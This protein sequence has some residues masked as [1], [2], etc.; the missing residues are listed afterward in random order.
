M[1]LWDYILLEWSFRSNWNIPRNR[2]LQ[3]LIVALEIPGW[4]VGQVMRV[5]FGLQG[6]AI[7]AGGL[8]VVLFPFYLLGQLLF[9]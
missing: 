8:I 7:M 6:L 4:F 9:S 3:F 1:G 2:F 5:L